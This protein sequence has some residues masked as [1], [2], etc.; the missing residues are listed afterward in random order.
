MGILS[1]YKDRLFKG[2]HWRLLSA[3]LAI[4]TVGLVMIYSAS[5]GLAYSYA[6][7]QAVWLA[8]AIPILFTVV[9]IGY[10]KLLSFAYTF[11]AAAVALL[12]LV[13]VLGETRLGAQRWLEIGPFSL[14]PS[15]FAKLAT[16]LALAQYLGERARNRYQMKRF[17]V[18]FFMVA[19]PMVLILRQPDLGT[20]LIFLPILFCVLFLWG[21]RIRYLAVTLLCGLASLPVFWFLLR[22]YQKKRLLVFLNPDIDPLGAGYT[23]VQ[24]K[25]AVGSGGLLGKGFLEGTQNRLHFL[26]E[27][28]TDF[29]FCVAAEEWGFVGSL[30]IL[31][32]FALLF[33]RMLE[34]IERTSDTRA[35][36]I[37][38]GI[39]SMMF[40]HVLINIGMTIGIMPIT[41]LP[42]PFVSYGGSSLVTMFASIGL[43][44]SIYKERS[45]F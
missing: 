40:F 15:E 26:P 6:A 14:Q 37:A 36:L 23:A 3:A 43:L 21:V 31:L 16:I 7:R 18:A 28:H 22:S 27:H 33:V 24:A 38:A 1:Y 30:V 5:R 44:I 2:F 9:A 10:R 11:Y 8:L 41:G 4:A 13:M 29:I 25:I 19:F 12:I 17:F 42:L 32:L 20:A 35:R 39:I 45:I 34:V